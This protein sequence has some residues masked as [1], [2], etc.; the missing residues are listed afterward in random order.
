MEIVRVLFGGTGIIKA[1]ASS[2]MS[3]N[4]IKFKLSGNRDSA[5]A[6]RLK[7]RSHQRMTS[8]FR[9]TLSQLL[10]PPFC[11]FSDRQLRELRNAEYHAE[12]INNILRKSIRQVVKLVVNEL[13][14]GVIQLKI[15]VSL[16]S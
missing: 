2:I 13:S 6:L 12:R 1:H 10:E 14:A 7:E 4:G 11:N 15:N 9:N 16:L 3:A 8:P 5:H